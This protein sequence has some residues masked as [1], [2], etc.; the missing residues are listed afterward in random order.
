[1]TTN[2]K[3]VAQGRL[4]VRRSGPLQLAPRASTP[5]AAQVF[6]LV[7]TLPAREAILHPPSPEQY[8]LF[9]HWLLCVMLAQK[10]RQQDDRIEARRG[11]I[12]NL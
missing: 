7:N 3:T 5:A 10:P 1:M 4:S 12:V 6:L 11:M 9:L 8:K 2:L